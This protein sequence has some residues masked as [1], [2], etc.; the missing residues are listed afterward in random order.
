MLDTTQE[1]RHP[2]RGGPPKPRFAGTRAD[3]KKMY[4]KR[5]LVQLL[6]VCTI[7]FIL[8]EIDASGIDSSRSYKIDPE[9]S[10]ISRVVHTKL[11][12]NLVRLVVSAAVYRRTR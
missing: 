6:Y 4:A 12:R 5:T 11:I 9:F 8:R 1:P 2:G 10:T 3:F 7:I